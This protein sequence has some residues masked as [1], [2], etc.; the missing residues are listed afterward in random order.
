MLLGFV[1]QIRVWIKDQEKKNLDKAN[2][3]LQAAL[4]DIAK[5]NLTKEDFLELQKKIAK[6]I[7]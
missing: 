5:P 3:E 1:A 6:R 2:E 4:D 7:P